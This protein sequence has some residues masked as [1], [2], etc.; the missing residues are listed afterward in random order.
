[1]GFCTTA[2]TSSPME[3]DTTTTNGPSAA[4]PNNI[5]PAFA[6]D[7]RAAEVG[8]PNDKQS[9]ATSRA[10]VAS[11][12]HARAE[13]RISG[14]LATTPRRHGTSRDLEKV[15]AAF[16][17]CKR[18]TEDGRQR[19]ERHCA[20]RG[21]LERSVSRKHITLPKESTTSQGLRKRLH[22]PETTAPKLH[23]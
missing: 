5:V 14:R 15:D 4:Q 3:I 2:P 7:A 16:R 9:L 11:R 13:I 8:Q 23:A 22:E 20:K 10:R 18:T 21:A 17:W 12:A 1:M 6:H 19:T